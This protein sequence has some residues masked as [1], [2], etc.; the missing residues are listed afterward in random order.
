MGIKRTGA[1]G[2]ADHVEREPDAGDAGSKPPRIR[3]GCRHF[4]LGGRDV[5]MRLGGLSLARAATDGAPGSHLFSIRQTLSHLKY[6]LKP[7]ARVL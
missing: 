7:P 2:G 6:T 1:A 3:E 4:E 5:G